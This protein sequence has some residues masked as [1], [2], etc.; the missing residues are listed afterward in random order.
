MNGL[1]ILFIFISGLVAGTWVERIINP[2]IV[3]PEAEAD[4]KRIELDTHGLPVDP[5]AMG[6]MIDEII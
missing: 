2:S 3:D 4:A 6:Q 1:I 5:K